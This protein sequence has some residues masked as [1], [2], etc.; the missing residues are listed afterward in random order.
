[1][2]RK[3]K[4]KTRAI[5][6]GYVEK[7]SAQIFDRY[8]K[9]ITDM[10][11]GYQ[12]LYALYRKDK[13]YYVGLASNLKSRIKHHLSNR[14]KGKWTHFSLYII[15]KAGHIKEL[16]SLLLRIAYP[17]GNTMKGKLRNSKNLLPILRKQVA[18]K[19]R[20]EIE[21][22]FEGTSSF[23]KKSKKKE[24]I[25]RKA[26]LPLKGLLKSYQRIYCFYKGN[27]FRAKVLPSGIIKMIPGGQLFNSPSSAAKAIIDKGAVNGW[28]FWK[29]KD[30]SGNLVPLKK[31]RK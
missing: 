2:A 17:A 19:S 15:R 27:K 8:Q 24:R 28:N 9:E 25:K 7:V 23:A 18:N 21:T 11:R 30:K 13:L 26:E 12:G 16:E 22:I 10:I 14:H 29:Y 4:Y 31:L 1:M 3:K 20:E 5:V 6:A